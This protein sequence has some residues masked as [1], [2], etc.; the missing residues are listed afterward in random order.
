[1]LGLLVLPRDHMKHQYCH[2]GSGEQQESDGEKLSDR[3]H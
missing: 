2:A 1:M 3:A